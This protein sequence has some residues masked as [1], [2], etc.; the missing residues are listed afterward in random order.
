M[1]NY[2]L[3]LTISIT[4][5]I[6]RVK[7]SVVAALGVTTGIAAFIILISFMNGLNGMLDGLILNRTPH[8]HIYN[9]IKPSENQ[10]IDYY[11][12]FENGFN[13]VR[14]IKPKQSQ[15]RI[16]NAKA[17]LYNLEKDPRVKGI[18][19]Q[20]AARVFY[21]A[22]SIQLNGVMNGINALDETRLFNFSDYI[23]KGSAIN[24]TKNSE[25]ILLGAGVAKKLSVTVGDRVQ[26]G[27]INGGIHNLKIVGIYQSGMADY[28]NV[29]SFGNLKTV[30]KLLGEGS[31]YISDI[32]V[33]LH[34]MKLATEMSK[35]IQSQYNLTAI[36]IESAN[37]QFETG[38]SIRNM[39]TYA[40]SITLLLVAGFGIYN[41]LNMMIF[42]KM[43]DIAILKATGFS[44][45]DVKLIFI[46]QALLIGLV[47]GIFGVLV[48]YGGTVLID[49]AP[50][51]TEALPT[52]KTFP[53]TYNPVHYVIA[54]VFALIS[55]FFAGYLPAKKAK[56]IDAVEIIRG[57]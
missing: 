30:Q 53:I 13:I 25:G 57:Q 41:I 17:L 6:S 49:Y 21:V 29:Q 46:F 15:V 3:L 19:P 56:K 52:M 48:G 26:I 51:E 20:V 36:D 31:N 18:T 55:T 44:G 40:V 34:N 42:E 4:H 39:I 37:A 14:S 10:P 24:L 23:I 5:L 8:I 38:T 28:D 32:N 2:K 1:T 33:K 50:F 43:N 47:G 35:Y 16:H 11:S 22:G 27:T 45:N 7:Q 9:D 12:E 54:V